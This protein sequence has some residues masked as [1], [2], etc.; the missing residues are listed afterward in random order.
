MGGQPCTHRSPLFEKQAR[1]HASCYQR[2]TPPRPASSTAATWRCER[3]PHTAIACWSL[4]VA[5]CIGLMRSH[6]TTL[7]TNFAQT[8]LHSAYNV[9]RGMRGRRHAAWLLTKCSPACAALPI[10]PVPAVM[11]PLPRPRRCRT[12]FVLW[13][14]R[15]ALHTV[16]CAVAPRMCSV[17]VVCLALMLRAAHCACVTRAID[18]RCGLRAARKNR[19]LSVP[20]T[21]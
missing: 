19:L 5:C 2:R 21:R 14:V 12:V 13:G 10:R 8:P 11:L 18:M 15:C 20:P 1:A 6:P 16:C 4:H 17:P 3:A 9:P 7:R